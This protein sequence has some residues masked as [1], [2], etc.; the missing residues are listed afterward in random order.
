MNTAVPAVPFIVAPAPPERDGSGARIT[1]AAQDWICLERGR[2]P[3]PVAPLWHPEGLAI[4]GFVEWRHKRPPR[5]RSRGGQAA[6]DSA[7]FPIGIALALSGDDG[8]AGD[9]S[10]R[11][12]RRASSLEVMGRHA[13][14][15]FFVP[16]ATTFVW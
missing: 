8:A 9:W 6:R 16:S 7:R 2:A 3:R 11:P 4:G 12:M 14:G 15:S 13:V 10:R 1:L 5:S